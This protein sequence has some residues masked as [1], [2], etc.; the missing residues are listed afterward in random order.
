MYWPSIAA[1][2]V[3]AISLFITYLARR[4]SSH[5]AKAAEESAATAK[6][7][8]RRARTP[9]LEGILTDPSPSSIDRFIYGV[10]NEGPQDLDDL[11]IYPIAVTGRNWA[12]DEI[13]FGPIILGQE[14]QFTFC[15]G[16]ASRT[17]GVSRAN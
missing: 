4:D 7:A 16:P 8:D 11:I 6:E 10:R 14:V 15:C 5:S 17:T 3:S 12:E 1:L 2:V 13:H 9:Q